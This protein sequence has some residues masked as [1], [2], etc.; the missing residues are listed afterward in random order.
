MHKFTSENLA[1]TIPK[2]KLLEVHVDISF[3]I[4][5]LIASY[6]EFGSHICSKYMLDNY[7]NVLQ[8]GSSEAHEAMVESVKA[9]YNLDKIRREIRILADIKEQIERKFPQVA[10]EGE[11]QIGEIIHANMQTLEGHL[12]ENQE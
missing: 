2:E 10:K 12:S 11:K 7:Q 6:S 4:Y 1:F 3:R 8:L 5:D 9:V